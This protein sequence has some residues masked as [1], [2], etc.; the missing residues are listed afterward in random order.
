MNPVKR[1]LSLDSGGIRGLVTIEILAKVEALLRKRYNDPNL[2]LGEYFDLIAGTS[3]GSIIATMLS[4]GLTVDELRKSY[5]NCSKQIF[6]KDSMLK[7]HKHTYSSAG[8]TKILKEALREESGDLATLGSQ[9]LRSLLL[10][11]LRNATTGSPWPLTNNAQSKFNDRRRR[12]CNLDLP[13][14]RL[15]RAS[16]A[17][18]AFFPP[19]RIKVGDEF[20]EFIDGAVSAYNNPAHLAYLHATLPAYRIGWARGE[21]NLFLLSVGTGY[22]TPKPTK[23]SLS[24]MHKLD[25]L[26]TTL[27]SA[28]TSASIHQD[29]C[30]RASGKLLYGA[31]IDEELKDMQDVGPKAESAFSYTRYNKFFDE[32]DLAEA[33]SASKKPF[34]MDNVELVDFLMDKGRSYAR[35]YVKESHLL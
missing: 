26:K 31:T 2:L 21:D 14:W 16:T 18:P 22:F 24:D 1:I 4:W 13:L 8:I 34:A 32:A 35:Y 19:E 6:T 12:D 33:A 5:L 10:L 30:C 25:H 17:A 27:K 9:R 7:Q 11:V 28:L 15:V 23:R 3:T 20:F 29:I